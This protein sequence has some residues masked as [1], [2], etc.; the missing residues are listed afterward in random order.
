MSNFQCEW[1]NRSYDP[2]GKPVMMHSEK[3][4]FCS[5]RCRSQ[6]RSSGYKTD[7]EKLHERIANLPPRSREQ[8]EWADAENKVAGLSVVLALVSTIVFMRTIFPSLLPALAQFVFM[9]GGGT[10]TLFPSTVPDWIVT[11][12]FYAIPISPIGWAAWLFFPIAY[13]L[14]LTILTAI[15][16]NFK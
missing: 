14:I 16:K 15:V 4:T 5:E 3:L 10:R 13:G 12:V 7:N 1:C 2:W 9:G 8:Q 11:V 6:A